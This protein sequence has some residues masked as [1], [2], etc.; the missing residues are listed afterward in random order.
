MDDRIPV[1]FSLR[2]ETGEV[3][4]DGVALKDGAVLCFEGGDFLE[5]VFGSKFSIFELSIFHMDEFKFKVEEA[6]ERFD[7][8]TPWIACWSVES[9]SHSVNLRY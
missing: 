4:K 5:R 7:L 3:S 2:L 6:G 9:E 8:L 1:E